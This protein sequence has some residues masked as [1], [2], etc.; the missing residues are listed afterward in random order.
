MKSLHK[1]FAMLSISG[2]LI[3]SS[4]AGETP[5]KSDAGDVGRITVRLT[6]DGSVYRSTRS[7]D[8]MCPLVPSAEQFGIQLESHDGSYNKS[9][10]SLATFEKEEGFPMGTYK[11]TA[12]YGN[13]DQEG[14]TAPYFKGEADDLKLLVGEETTATVQATLANS[15]VS[16]RYSDKFI[17]TFPAYSAS[18]C[19]E[20][21]EAVIFAQDET[22]PAFVAPSTISLNVTLSNEQGQ[23]VTVSPASFVAQEQR[24]Y[25]ITIDVEGELSLQTAS[26][27]V[28]FEENVVAETRE[29]ML[30]DELFNAP[31]PYIE[32]TDAIK[33]GIVAY[34]LI[35]LSDAVNP[36]FHIFAFGGINSAKLKVSTTDGI[37]PVFGNEVELVN[38]D[39]NTQA[40]L[41]AAG[42]DCAG[43]FNNPGQMAVVNLNDFVKHLHPGTYKVSL[44][45]T[46]ELGKTVADED[47]LT[48]TATV[49]KVNWSMEQSANKP[50][51]TG[52]QVEM[53]IYS[54]C[55]LLK[56]YIT[57]KVGN[58]DADATFNDIT[59][60][61]TDGNDRYR[62]TYTI[63]T[64]KIL[65]S[66]IDVEAFFVEAGSVSKSAEV[67][68]PAYTLQTDA[69]SYKVKVKVIYDDPVVR[70]AIVENIKVYRN[71]TSFNAANVYHDTEKSLIII[72]GLSPGVTY[73]NFKFSLGAS[74]TSN[75]TTVPAFKTATADP[76]PNEGFGT[77]HESITIPNIN[78]GGQYRVS[79]T[80]YQLRSSIVR[81]EPDG[82][83]SLNAWTCYENS[84]NK[85]TWFLVPSTFLEG[86]WV[87]I[88]SV[89]YNHNGTT[90]SKSGG[91]F[92]TKYYCEN[93]PS[94]SQLEKSA[95]ELFLGEYSYNGTGEREDGIVEGVEFETR[96]SALSFDYNFTK[97]G[98]GDAEVVIR[99]VDKA[100]NISEVTEK[101]SGG[102][103]SSKTIILPDYEFLADSDYPA[104]SKVDKLFI[105]FRST[106]RGVTPQ[107]N[108][109][110]GSALNESS[111]LGNTT[112]SANSYHA[113]AYGS[114]LKVKN[115]KLIYNEATLSRGGA[116]KVAKK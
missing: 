15:M 3:L 68:M 55:P 81:S 66:K 6:A 24:H 83:A 93:S 49:N 19:S 113:F 58:A 12:T 90:P 34:E 74:L 22:R 71:T 29:I 78:V 51:Y 61:G 52:E 87:I 32:G 101:L 63:T 91:A 88:R 67:E 14:F 21:H 70:E 104:N 47:N 39:A 18:I 77:T 105:C 103:N 84:G 73:N 45:V 30:T 109:P 106:E 86:D 5:W 56:D 46:D 44:Y 31:A 94:D 25:I 40:Q 107:I 114:E 2:A 27:S 38:A 8:D 116:S 75:S 42:V 100:G 115:V 10:E 82:W 7:S 85:N 33:D 11:L 4:C 13:P 28:T 69:F 54:N 57:F 43:L 102:I 99:V 108:I 97:V 35:P 59:D 95:G 60:S 65:E 17:H 96:P 80:D 26:L 48:F 23:R 76:I 64:S 98:E 72:S 53:Y 62:Y 89:G 110:T 112:L 92:N 50:K 20:G 1:G 41:K 16:V 37:M 9:W 111:G 79:P 36:E